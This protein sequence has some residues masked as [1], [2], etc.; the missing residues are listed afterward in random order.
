MLQNSITRRRRAPYNTRS[1]KI[2]PV[3]TPGGKLVAQYVPKRGKIP[4]CGGCKKT[5]HGIKQA[6]PAAFKRMK[7]SSRTVARTYGGV[8]CSKCTRSK[9]L[10]SVLRKN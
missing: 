7:K 4:V 9:I 6:R 3:R 1:N 5:L 10:L 8:L 2:R